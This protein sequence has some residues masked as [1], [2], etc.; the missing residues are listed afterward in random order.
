MPTY[1]ICN[2]FS[3]E[4]REPIFDSIFEVETDLKTFTVPGFDEKMDKQEENY[5]KKP[6]LGIW[7]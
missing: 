5:F 3:M 2:D 7:D 1:S 4:V 6:H